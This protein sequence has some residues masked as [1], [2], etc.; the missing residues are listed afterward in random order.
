MFAFSLIVENLEYESEYTLNEQKWLCQTLIE[1]VFMLA[2]I[3]VF[4]AMI[5]DLLPTSTEFICKC[6]LFIAFELSLTI[7][8]VIIQIRKFKLI[9]VVYE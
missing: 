2:G 1:L 9:E 4:R 3:T 8:F 6:G 5:I 7:S